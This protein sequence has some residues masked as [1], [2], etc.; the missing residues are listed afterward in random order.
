M[1]YISTS[2]S[3]ERARFKVPL[4]VQVQNRHGRS[5]PPVVIRRVALAR[6]EIPKPVPAGG[7]S[8]QAMIMNA[9]A[10]RLP[11]TPYYPAPA[12]QAGAFCGCFSK[13]FAF[14]SRE[15]PIPAPFGATFHMKRLY[16]PPFGATFHVKRCVRREGGAEVFERRHVP[17]ETQGLWASA[18]L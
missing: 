15:T 6:Q 9:V 10:L 16:P 1:P 18:L 7:F 2:K 8:C 14:V 17:R 11:L 13:S 12:K 3:Q 4:C 5:L